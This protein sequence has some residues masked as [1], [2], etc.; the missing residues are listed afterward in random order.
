MFR[1]K[2][3]SAGSELSDSR[4]SMASSPL[5]A[6]TK[7]ACTFAAAKVSPKR[8]RSSQSSSAYRIFFM[9]ALMGENL[10]VN[11]NLFKVHVM[12]FGSVQTTQGFLN[13]LG[14]TLTKNR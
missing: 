2:M 1:S 12:Y 4:W 5:E 3:I 14:K 13:N 7:S 6:Y 11:T 9:V 8:K 10:V